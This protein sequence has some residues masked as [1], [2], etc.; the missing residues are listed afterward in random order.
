MPQMLS[1]LR[2]FTPRS[3][4]FNSSMSEVV[5]AF[6]R[7][8]R[9]WRDARPGIYRILMGAAL[10][11]CVP[12]IPQ[13]VRSHATTPA[14]PSCAIH[15]LNGGMGMSKP[16]PLFQG[17]H[18][19]YPTEFPH[20]DSMWDV[21]FVRGVGFQPPPMESPLTKAKAVTRFCPVSTTIRTVI[22]RCNGWRRVSIV[23]KWG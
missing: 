10:P 23:Y 12:V 19:L 15:G 14:L 7:S 6:A 11:R 13:P 9:D 5:R 1:L 21:G 4:P 20:R 17:E 3:F 16:S 22:I 18:C 2:L 8:S